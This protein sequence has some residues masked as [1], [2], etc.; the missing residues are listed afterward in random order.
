MA[1]PKQ[2]RARKGAVESSQ[3]AGV[4]IGMWS[5]PD[6][7]A[8]LRARLRSEL[9]LASDRLKAAGFDLVT[10]LKPE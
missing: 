8:P 6:S 2:S 4:A 5:L 1:W 3:C 9:S 7:T 10:E